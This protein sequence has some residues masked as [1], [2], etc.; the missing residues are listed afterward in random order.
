MKNK[1]LTPINY[2]RIESKPLKEYKFWWPLG[3]CL[4]SVVTYILLP[5]QPQIISEK[6]LIS[7]VNSI[8]GILA[9]FYIAS[10][11]AVS[12]FQSANLDEP[13]KGSGMKAPVY[14]EGKEQFIP[15]N[16]RSFLCYLF[17]YCAF[18]S[19][20]ILGFG[21]AT[22]VIHPSITS[23]TGQIVF[24]LKLVWIACYSLMI[25]SLIVT[26]FLGLHY[27]IDRMHR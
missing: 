7:Q 20:F 23:L 4:L 19:I 21:I 8:I 13:I 3:V 11:A 2:L 24:F 17:G 9:G 14:L 12:T 18:L 1:L 5:E 22:Q 16:R 10:L 25:G 27:L 15:L 26:T 6:G